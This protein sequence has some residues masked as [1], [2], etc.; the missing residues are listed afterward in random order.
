MYLPNLDV[1]RLYTPQ[2]VVDG[3]TDAPGWNRD[4]V[5]RAVNER[6]CAMP[7]SPVIRLEDGPFGSFM[8]HLD[9]EAPEE[10]L[11]VW[12]VAYA[13]GWAMVEIGAGENEGLDMP[14]Y[15]MVKSLTYLGS[16]S[17]GETV[18]MGESFRRYGTVAI[19]QG[20]GGGPIYGYA[21]AEPEDEDGR[22][23]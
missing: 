14:H 3:I 20:A 22:Q 17:G 13:P 10:E 7:D 9:G 1:S 6:L 12:L 2:F 11:D 23:H 5:S 16:W 21:H 4:K 8:V 15:N 19:V 18:Y